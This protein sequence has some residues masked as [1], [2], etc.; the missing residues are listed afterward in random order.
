MYQPVSFDPINDPWLLVEESAYEQIEGLGWAVGPVIVKDKKYI[1]GTRYRDRPG[2]FYSS[3]PMIKAL[4]TDG[5][6]YTWS[7]PEIILSHTGTEHPWVEDPH[8]YYDE[9]TGRLWMSWGGG[10]CYVSELD[11]E[12]GR[13]IFRP[14]S[15]EFY[16]HP[17]KFHTP[18]STWPET[19]DGWCGDEF[20]SCW[21]EG[22]SLY[23]HN[24]YWYHFASYGNMN[25][26]YSIR[27]G[28]G[29]S[30]TG[31]FYDKHGTD[32]MKFD[33]ERNVYGQ[34]VL[35]GEEGDKLVPGHPHIWEEDGKYYLG[36]DFRKDLTK[37]HDLMGIRS[38]YWVD[39]W[40]TIYM[41]LNV[42]LNADEYPE[43]AGGR[44]KVAIRNMGEAESLLAVDKT[45]LFITTK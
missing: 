18:V 26:N 5:F 16:T 37:E 17:E 22:A 24:G 6:R 23:K 27:Y 34:S 3:I 9:E 21:H 40:P 45:S 39:D 14:D 4:S 44:I 42:T 11:P 19:H 1:Y 38:L 2:N 28:R 31:P 41:P 10:I 7:E 29:K 30:P 36:Y 32:M 33:K 12:D 13:L 15:S 25:K 43:A 20:S 8:C 35:L